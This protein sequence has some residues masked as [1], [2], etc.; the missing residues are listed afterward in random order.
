M[1][2][3]AKG[4]GDYTDLHT[5]LHKIESKIAEKSDSVDWALLVDWPELRAE[6][7]AAAT[8]NLE[9]LLHQAAPPP[10]ATAV[11]AQ[12]LDAALQQRLFSGMQDNLQQLET[13]VAEAQAPAAAPCPAP[14]PTLTRRSRSA[15]PKARKVKSKPK[16]KS[17]A[18]GP[19]SYARPG[20]CRSCGQKS[21]R[22][23][24]RRCFVCLNAQGCAACHRHESSYYRSATEGSNDILCN[25]CYRH[26]NERLR[27]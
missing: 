18:R 22:T 15:S 20:R 9:L 10:L 25:S 6:L 21:D 16:S 24:L 5:F 4:H 19:C 27:K 12:R 23:C 1:S 2:A 13:A 17:A 7:E 11:A 3:G 8:P 14:F 26:K